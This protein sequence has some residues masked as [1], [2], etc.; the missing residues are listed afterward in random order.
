MG[1]QEP[2]LYPDGDWSST[3]LWGREAERSREWAHQERAY[4]EHRRKR[5]RLWTSLFI[6]G[7][8]LWVAI[9]VALYLMVL[10]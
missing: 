10:R 2:P 9:G 4:H 5:I 1:K 6:G 3:P 8:A 7:L